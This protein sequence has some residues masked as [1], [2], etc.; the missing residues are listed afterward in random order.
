[1][2][3]MPD[4]TP[5]FRG[6]HLI[7]LHFYNGEGYSAEY[8]EHLSNTLEIAE[9]GAVE[10]CAGAD[11]ICK[12]CPHLRDDNCEY[13]ENAE[14]DIRRMDSTALDLLGLSADTSISWKEVR[15]KVEKIFHE[16][17]ELYCK[18]CNWLSAC[19]KNVRFRKLISKTK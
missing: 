13:Y 10:I 9:K 15:E 12:K 2:R 6:H 11:C 7:C 1:M 19:E 14:V 18:D 4:P 8:I 17:Y 16:W 5:I 3:E